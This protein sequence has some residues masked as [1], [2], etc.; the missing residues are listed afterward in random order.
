VRGLG[1]AGVPEGLD[2]GG[3]GGMGATLEVD[4]ASASDGKA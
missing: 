1:V 2:E 4:H 3:E